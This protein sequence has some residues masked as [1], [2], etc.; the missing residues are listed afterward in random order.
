[1]ERYIA[2]MSTK[3]IRPESWFA[4]TKL[5]GRCAGRCLKRS[6]LGSKKRQRRTNA[7]KIPS[8]LGFCVRGWMP[9]RRRRPADGPPSSHKA[10]HDK[11]DHD[12]ARVQ[13]RA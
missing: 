4:K 8:W 12:I 3:D 2:D 10:R 7:R 13:A 9:T 5:S 6:R 1:M 11:G